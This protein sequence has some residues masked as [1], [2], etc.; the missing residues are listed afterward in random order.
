MLFGEFSIVIPNPSWPARRGQ[1]PLQQV[2]GSDIAYFIEK[3][4]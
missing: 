2:I 1:P 4:T 3:N